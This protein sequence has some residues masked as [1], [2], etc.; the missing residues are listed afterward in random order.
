MFLCLAD[1]YTAITLLMA[2]LRFLILLAGLSASA[3][4]SVAAGGGSGMT[5]SR[6]LGER[7]FLR[8]RRGTAYVSACIMQTAR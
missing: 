5:R 2:V 8:N 4:S 1:P 6:L 7:Y 3:A